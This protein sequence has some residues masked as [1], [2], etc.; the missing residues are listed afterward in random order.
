MIQQ[1][2]PEDKQMGIKVSIQDPKKQIKSRSIG[3]VGRHAFTAQIP[4]E[5]LICLQ[6][7]TDRWFGREELELEVSIETGVGATDYD[8]IAKLESLSAIEVSIRQLN[9][10]V[11]SIIAEQVY[12]KKREA[13]FRDTSEATDGHVRL[14]SI[15]QTILLVGS[16]FWQI[17]H[18][19]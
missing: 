5:H 10:E 15:G 8:E 11:H 4:G 19:K 14:W 9:D 17:R 12:Q 16:A 1:S 6:T 13:E 3:L 7:T 18:L 2:L